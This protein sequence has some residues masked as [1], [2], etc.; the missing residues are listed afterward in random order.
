MQKV[1]AHAHA[2]AR[3]LIPNDGRTA[4]LTV[5][6]VVHI[7]PLPPLRAL[8]LPLL[9]LSSLAKTIIVA[10]KKEKRGRRG[11]GGSAARGSCPSIKNSCHVVVPFLP[12]PSQ[13]VPAPLPAPCIAAFRILNSSRAARNVQKTTTLCEGQ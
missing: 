4:R 7:L 13:S 1:N 8:P 9:L 2:H 12:C 10:H 5:V 6:V 3:T 11:D